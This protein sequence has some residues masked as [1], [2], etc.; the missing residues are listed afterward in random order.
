MKLQTTTK[1]NSVMFQEKNQKDQIVLSLNLNM[2]FGDYLLECNKPMRSLS[3]KQRVNT[4]TSIHKM[5]G[6]T[7]TLNKTVT[8]GGHTFLMYSFEDVNYL[9]S[10][11]ELI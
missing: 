8:K 4:Q 2:T 10:Y 6:F 1:I 9:C 3:G 11:I 7:Y 5:L